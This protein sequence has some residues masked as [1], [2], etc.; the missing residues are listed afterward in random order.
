MPNP[1]RSSE[2]TLETRKDTE[3]DEKPTAC[4]VLYDD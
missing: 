3:D 2:H 1:S 4:V